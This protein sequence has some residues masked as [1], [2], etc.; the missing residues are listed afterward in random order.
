V[1]VESD[2]FGHGLV[3]PYSVEDVRLEGWWF[4]LNGGA[5]VINL[6]GEYHRGQETGGAD[7]RERI[8][9]Q[10][11][12]LKDFVESLDLTSVAR[13]DG[14]SN[15][16]AGSIAGALANPGK[17]YAVYLFHGKE[18]GQWGAHFVG[19]PGSYR[20]TFT[21]NAVPAGRYRLE[22]IDPMGGKLKESKRLNWRGGDLRVTTPT[23]ALDVALRMRA[24]SAR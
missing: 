23:Y 16:P 18:D 7:T 5:G 10:R 8:V 2:Y 4:M 15:I 22:W 13:F 17:Q 14:L 3:K 9:P 24:T 21:L 11:K 1:D 12:I 19:V 6:N 20:D